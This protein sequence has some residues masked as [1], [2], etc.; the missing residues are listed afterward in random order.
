MMLLIQADCLLVEGDA[1]A[2]AEWL[3][4]DPDTRSPQPF[5]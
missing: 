1:E 3:E 5:L 2:D 4:Q